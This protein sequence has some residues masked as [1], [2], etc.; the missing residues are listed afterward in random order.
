[1]NILPKTIEIIR[2]TLER[3]S[4]INK[5]PTF[6]RVVFDRYISGRTLPNDYSKYKTLESVYAATMKYVGTTFALIAADRDPELHHETWAKIFDSSSLG[7]WLDATEVVCRRAS[8]L[9]NNIQ[10]YCAEY[11]DYRNHSRRSDLDRIAEHMCVVTS[12]LE[13]NGYSIK[14]PR[15]L[16]IIRALRHSVEIRNKCAHG[17]LESPFFSRVDTDYHKALKIILRL[18]PFSKFVFWGR[19]GSNAIELVESPPER[20]HK[21]RTRD[22]NFWAESDLLSNGFTKEIPFMEYK[23]YSQNIYFLNDRVSADDPTSE[24]IDYQRGNV[25]YRSVQREW[26]DTGNPSIRAVRPRNYKQHIDALSDNFTWREISLTLSGMNATANET[27]V[28]VFTTKINLGGRPIEV[29]LYVG[30]TTNLTER[31]KSYIKIRKGYD[32]SRREIAYMF[33]T[34]DKDVKMFFAP[35]PATRIASVERAIYET[36]M[37]EFNMIAPPV[38]SERGL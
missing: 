29:I 10:N 9:P 20:H 23:E 14:Q 5:L 25:I 6:I 16:N 38:T 24:F 31:V 32:D 35:M 21:T 18:I 4:T 28:Y 8:E 37:P 27:G 3:R 17:A 36:A 12:E 33:E 1:M 22:A 11:S 15:S 30:R 26:R 13:K 2:R 34:Y 19:H 7:G